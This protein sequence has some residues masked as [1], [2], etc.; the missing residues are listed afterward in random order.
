MGQGWR[1]GDF[2]RFYVARFGD[3]GWLRK[4]FEKMYEWLG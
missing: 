4:R 3:A 2:W 1:L